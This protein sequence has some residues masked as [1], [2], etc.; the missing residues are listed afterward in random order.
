MAGIG[1]SRPI[2]SGSAVL[3][4]V[5]IL[6][7]SSSLAAKARVQ[8]QTPESLAVAITIDA[9][10][11]IELYQSVPNLKIIDTRLHE[12]RTMGYIE[13]SVNLPSANTNCKS[14]A[15]LTKNKDQAI[16][17]YCNGILAD[18]SIAAIQVA[19]DC[20]YKRLFWLRGGFVEWEDKDYPFVVE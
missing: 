9:E 1:L 2:I 3:F 11:L 7:S 4:S 12:D 16:V 5:A 14:L 20:G 17:F 8:Q 15:K 18:A 6:A 19:A 13:T 10:N